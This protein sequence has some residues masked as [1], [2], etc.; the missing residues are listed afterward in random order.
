MLETIQTKKLST[1]FED[2]CSIDGF[3]LGKKKEVA[4]QLNTISRKLLHK[5]SLRHSHYSSILLPHQNC[6]QFWYSE[7]NM[8]LRNKLPKMLRI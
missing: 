1:L 3:R 6:I 7:A 2:D 8:F 4:I 5:K